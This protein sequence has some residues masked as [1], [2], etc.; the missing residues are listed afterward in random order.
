MKF[1][2]EFSHTIIHNEHAFAKLKNRLAD[3]MATTQVSEPSEE[4]K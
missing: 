1:K 2:E 3:T 4:M